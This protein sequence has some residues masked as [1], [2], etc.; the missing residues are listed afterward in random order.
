MDL[1]STV[2]IRFFHG[3]C[4]SF[5]RLLPIKL[6][7]RHRPHGDVRA[8]GNGSFGDQLCFRERFKIRDDEDRLS[9]F[10][11]GTFIHNRSRAFRRK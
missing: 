2:N 7:C 8:S 6:S 4:H 5:L 1:V 3:G 11:E 10:H 9:F